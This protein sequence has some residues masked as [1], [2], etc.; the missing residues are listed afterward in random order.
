M[1]IYRLWLEQWADVMV[2]CTGVTLLQLWFTRAD[3]FAMVMVL[4]YTSVRTLKKREA[5]PSI[6][7]ILSL[8][9]KQTS[10]SLLNTQIYDLHNKNYCLLS[11]ADCL[12]IQASQVAFKMVQGARQDVWISSQNVL[13]IMTKSVNIQARRLDSQ[14]TQTDCLTARQMMYTE[15]FQDL[16]R[17]PVSGYTYSCGSSVTL[18]SFRR[19]KIF[20]PKVSDFPKNSKFAK[21]IFFLRPSPSLY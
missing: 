1:A 6:A 2:L 5:L 11:Y 10:Y 14:E 19:I 3:L 20:Q 21:S 7:T 12:G 18:N 8:L 17:Q 16:C 15:N 9:F 13:G 4:Q